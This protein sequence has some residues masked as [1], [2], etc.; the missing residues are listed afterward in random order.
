ML[1]HRLHLNQKL[2]DSSVTQQPSRDGFG[3]ALIELGRKNPHVVVLC[4]DLIESTRVEPFA[5]HFPDRF[6]EVGVAEQNM[7]AVAAGLG[8]GKYF[9]R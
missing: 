2:F 1:N 8:F 5:R 7:A 9:Y 3:D 6:F 4:A